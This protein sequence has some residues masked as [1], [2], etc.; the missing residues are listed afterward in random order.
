MTEDYTRSDLYNSLVI[1]QSTLVINGDGGSLY[2]RN[3]PQEEE[4]GPW[5][6]ADQE[7]ALPNQFHAYHYCR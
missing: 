5:Q 1:P 2:N 4:K 3:K 6:Q 7:M